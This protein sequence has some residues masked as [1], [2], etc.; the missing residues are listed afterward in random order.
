MERKLRL[1]LRFSSM[2]KPGCEG[3]VVSEENRTEVGLI[4]GVVKVSTE[5]STWKGMPQALQPSGC[6]AGWR[7]GWVQGRCGCVAMGVVQGA[8]VSILRS[9]DR[10]TPIDLIVFQ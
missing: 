4:L 3:P 6:R 9:F 7:R 10:L 8:P 1:S 5:R 2:L